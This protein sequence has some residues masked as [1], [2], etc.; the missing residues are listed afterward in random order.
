[1]SLR[2]LFAV[3]ALVATIA[4]PGAALAQ[5]KIAY[6]DY[7]R[8]LLEVDDGKAAR[9]RLQKWLDTRQKEI[10]SEQKALQQEK[11]TLDKQAAAM[12]DE[13]RMQKAEALQRRFF[14]LAQKL[15]QSRAEAAN[16]ER[17]E[18]EPIVD[19]IDQIIAE[20]ANRTDLAFV[21]EKRESGV[22]FARSQ[23]DITNEVIRAYNAKG[24]K[25]KKK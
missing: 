9:A 15:E 5:E 23:F 22:V 11:A 21:L 19:R 6:V 16:R 25:P 1:M 10:E 3:A 4:A 7:Q 18:M 20:I 17:K 12:S 8:V 13:A 2:N 24:A 14:E